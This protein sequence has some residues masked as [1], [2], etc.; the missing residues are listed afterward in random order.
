MNSFSTFKKS[1]LPSILFVGEPGTGKTATSA[2]IGRPLIVD[3]D[4][5]VSGAFS[6][7]ASVNAPCKADFIVPHLT[8]TGEQV[9]RGKRWKAMNDSIIE[10]IAKAKAEK[11]PY[12]TLVVDSCSSFIEIILDEVRRLQ[13]RKISDLFK[14]IADEPLKIQDWGVFKGLFRE[15]V[16]RLKASGLVF[17]LTA[18]M[19]VEKDEMTGIQM[20]FINVPGQFRNEIAGLFSECWISTITE[21]KK[22]SKI[23][24][25]YEI[26]TRPGPG[27]KSLGLKSGIQL[28]PRE[29]VNYEELNK[30]IFP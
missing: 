29:P 3:L 7:L 6:Y 11:N 13:G 17:I 22:D 18:H 5:N 2:M 24:Y 1:S 19:N 28:Q 8:E 20:F 30:R 14:G 9:P 12:T 25:R 10:S 21:E 15:W 26:R 16:L 4:N 27:Q 23:S